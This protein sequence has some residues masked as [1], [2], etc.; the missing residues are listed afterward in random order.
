MSGTGPWKF[1]SYNGPNFKTHEYDQLILGRKGEKWDAS[2]AALQPFLAKVE[3]NFISSS[4]YQKRSS[5]TFSKLFSSPHLWKG[6]KQFQ[7]PL[8]LSKILTKAITT[9]PGFFFGRR[10]ANRA[11]TCISSSDSFCGRGPAATWMSEKNPPSQDPVNLDLW[12]I[13]S[14]AK[15]VFLP[16]FGSVY[17]GPNSSKTSSAKRIGKCKCKRDL[18]IF[19][20]KRTAV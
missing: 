19:L 11:R 18:H 14:L 15:E 10:H 1:T 12:G 16:T 17:T 4:R 5:R 3:V 13:R 8:F 7:Q 20:R 6:N 9:L 2:Q